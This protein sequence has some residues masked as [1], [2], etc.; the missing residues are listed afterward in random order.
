[1]ASDNKYDCELS[2]ERA[3]LTLFLKRW[4]GQLLIHETEPDADAIELAKRILDYYLDLYNEL[5]T[6]ASA[7]SLA[8]DESKALHRTLVA[9]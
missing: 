7:V 8:R 3:R 9:A 2:A 1:M 5:A 4:R 6:F